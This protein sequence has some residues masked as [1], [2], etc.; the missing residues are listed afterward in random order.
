MPFD[1]LIET[2]DSWASNNPDSDVFA[3]IGNTSYVPD[4]IRHIR[5]L[6][7]SEF[8]EIIRESEIVVAH[9][10]TGTIIKAL[11]LEK[12]IF[13]MPRKASLG[14]TRNDHQIYTARLFEKSGYVKS[15]NDAIRL[16]ELLVSNPDKIGSS[17]SKLASIELNKAIKSFIENSDQ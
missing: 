8:D 6:K 14:E 11:E 17:I 7:S 3:Q 4:H 9:A 2:V 1:R 13:V 15:F 16:N 12:P 5:N 10:G